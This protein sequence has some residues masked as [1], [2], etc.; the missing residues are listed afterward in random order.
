[1]GWRNGSSGRVLL[2]KYEG[3][4]SNPGNPQKVHKLYSLYEIIAKY[5]DKRQIRSCPELGI[6]ENGDWG[7]IF[8]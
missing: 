3:L 7:F 4:H 5:S 8:G 2:S 6:W 1:M